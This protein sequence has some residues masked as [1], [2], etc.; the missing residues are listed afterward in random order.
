MAT[1]EQKPRTTPFT[2]TREPKA[3]TA[4]RRGCSRATMQRILRLDAVAAGLLLAVPVGRDGSLPSQLRS[5][6]AGLRTGG[7]DVS[8]RETGNLD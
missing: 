5:L 7:S 4:R 6:S 2:Q 3:T 8:T 1:S